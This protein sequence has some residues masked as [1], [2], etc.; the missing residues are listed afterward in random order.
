M[1]E[2]RGT[3]QEPSESSHPCPASAGSP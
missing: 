1:A 2:E 3:K